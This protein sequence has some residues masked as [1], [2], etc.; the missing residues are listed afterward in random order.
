[1]GYLVRM[2][3][4]TVSNL[5]LLLVLWGE[6]TLDLYCQLWSDYENGQH[7]LWKMLDFLFLTSDP[8]VAS[9]P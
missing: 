3:V 8:L 1:M 9:L 6:S 4:R 2:K 7:A 5:F